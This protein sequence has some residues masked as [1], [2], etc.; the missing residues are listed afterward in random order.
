[1]R[2]TVL[3]FA[4]M[5]AAL[6]MAGSVVLLSG[7]GG[8]D[9]PVA[10]AQTA[11]EDQDDSARRDSSNVGSA[12]GR[13]DGR[14]VSMRPETDGSQAHAIPQR[15][16]EPPPVGLTERGRAALEQARRG[17]AQPVERPIIE[18]EAPPSGPSTN[19]PEN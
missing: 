19:G 3:L 17:N 11:S 9:P 6:L 16:V 2:R 1:M 18:I 13:A 14:G 15:A 10:Q 8:G 5:A 4:A 12:T 7:V